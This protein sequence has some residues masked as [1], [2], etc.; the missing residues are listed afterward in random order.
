VKDIVIIAGCLASAIGLQYA[1]IADWVSRAGDRRR[2]REIPPSVVDSVPAIDGGSD[3]G[4]PDSDPGGSLGHAV[5][6]PGATGD[7]RQ[8]SG[9]QMIE[10]DCAHE[11]LTEA[12]LET[13]EQ[14]AHLIASFCRLQR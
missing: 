10:L 11:F 9:S 13:A 8:L 3:T 14:V 2:L 5:W 6:S 1:L 12:R 4:D 7:R